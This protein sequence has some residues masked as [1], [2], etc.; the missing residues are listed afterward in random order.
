M[1]GG[2]KDAEALGAMPWRGVAL[3]GA[4]LCNSA[5]CGRALNGE[6]LAGIAV[7]GVRPPHCAAP[8]IT[9]RRG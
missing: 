4:K 8:T 2:V 6:T 7:H 9:R 5:L 3:S 1:Q